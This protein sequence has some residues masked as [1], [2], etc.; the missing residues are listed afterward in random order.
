MHD[1]IAFKESPRNPSKVFKGEINKEGVSHTKAI[2]SF[3]KDEEVYENI[4]WN[5]ENLLTYQGKLVE[6]NF[7]DCYSLTLVFSERKEDKLANKR[8]D[9]FKKYFMFD[10]QNIDLMYI[11][12]IEENVYQL[13]TLTLEECY[14]STIL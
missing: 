12:N 14:F 11:T 2:T 10:S 7:H 8:K 4:G 5:N 13:V 9:F 1:L 3:Y 6:N